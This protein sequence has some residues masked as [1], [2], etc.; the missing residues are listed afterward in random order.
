MISCRG[1]ASFTVGMIAGEEIVCC[2][3]LASQPFYIFWDWRFFY[4]FFSWTRL[5]IL[6]NPS[7]FF[8]QY[9]EKKA[10]RR[11]LDYKVLIK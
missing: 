6:N 5:F 3:L 4:F 9:G 2:F 11:A 10:C 8:L 1:Y 7:W